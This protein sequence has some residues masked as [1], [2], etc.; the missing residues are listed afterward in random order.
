MAEMEMRETRR[1]RTTNSRRDNRPDTIMIASTVVVE[2]FG[3]ENYLA[4]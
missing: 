3:S 1:V 2:M 4:L